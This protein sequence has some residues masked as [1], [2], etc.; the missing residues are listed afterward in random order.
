MRQISSRRFLPTLALLLAALP[1]AASAQTKG[2]APTGWAASWTEP[3]NEKQRQQRELLKGL[4]AMQKAHDYKGEVRLCT[5]AIQKEPKGTS[6]YLLRAA[7]Y[8]E[9]KENDRALAD[10]DHAQG[11]IRAENRPDLGARLL[12]FRAAVNG[13]RRDYPAAVNDL[14]GAIKLDGKSALA[15]NDLAWIRATAPDDSIRNGRESVRAAQKANALTTAP[16][17]TSI[18][19]LAAAYAEAADYPRAVEA[20]KRALSLAGTQIKDAA[21]AKKFQDGASARL[22]LFEQH[23]PYRAD[24]PTEI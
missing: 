2:G 14:Q 6:L 10:V 17:Y 23:Q 18:D 8:S 5:Q 3:A 20:E 19:T 24:Y 22:H 7:A 9:T 12:V 11:L 4:V 21:R 15:W 16:N 13:R 1:L